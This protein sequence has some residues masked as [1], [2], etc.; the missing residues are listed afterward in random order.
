MLR[1]AI[2][3]DAQ[4]IHSVRAAAIT[5]LASTH[6]VPAELHEWVSGRTAD[7]YLSPI[8]LQIVIVAER[9]DAIVG[10][11]HLDPATRKIEAIYVYPNHSRQGIG[12]MLLRALEIEA[13]L[14]DIKSLFLEA[15]FNA[16]P[17][18]LEAGYA[19]IDNCCL[20][21]GAAMRP[22]CKAMFRQLRGAADA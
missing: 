6:Y 20:P 3:S 8:Q 12:M 16:E 13:E 9:N 19:P 5:A 17:F 14:L 11:G 15:S 22:S 10:F 1:R 21:G 7:S 4:Q 18:Y 2:P